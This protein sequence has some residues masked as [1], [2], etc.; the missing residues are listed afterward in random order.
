MQTTSLHLP[1]DLLYLLRIVAVRRA[2]HTG[3]RPS[4][5]DVVRVMLEANR[6]QL[7]AEASPS[8]DDGSK[9]DVA[10]AES[11]GAGMLRATPAEHKVIERAKLAARA[12]RRRADRE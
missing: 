7:E 5:S 2:S 12:I 8:T 3:G 4:V 10:A 11:E 1:A 6:R 9:L